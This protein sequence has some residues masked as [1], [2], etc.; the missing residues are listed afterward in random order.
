MSPNPCELPACA[1][2][3]TDPKERALR[4]LRE[5]LGHWEGGAEWLRDGDHRSPQQNRADVKAMWDHARWIYTIDL[6]LGMTNPPSRHVGEVDDATRS[7]IKAVMVTWAS[8][9]IQRLAPTPPPADTTETGTQEIEIAVP[10]QYVTLDQMA[11]MVP[12][13]KRTLEKL[14]GRDSNPLPDPDIQGGGGKP[15]EWD[16]HRIRPWLE[17]EY[18]RKFPADYPNSRG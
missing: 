15:N 11:A 12:R 2:P 13:S 7:E 14:I 3:C 1:F 4:E 18:G 9:Q 8:D 6:A 17:Q 10:P 16:W 5:F